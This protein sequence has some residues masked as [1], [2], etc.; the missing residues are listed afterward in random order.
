M[1]NCRLCTRYFSSSDALYRHELDHTRYACRNCGREFRTHFCALVHS[2]RCGTVSIYIFS[3]FSFSFPFRLGCDW[4]FR[5]HR[6]HSGRCSSCSSRCWIGSSWTWSER[7][8]REKNNDNNKHDNCI[9][10]IC[11]CWCHVSTINVEHIFRIHLCF[12]DCVCVAFSYKL[13]RHACFRSF[14]ICSLKYHVQS[15]TLL[16][17]RFLL[18]SFGVSK[19]PGA[20]VRSPHYGR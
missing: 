15:L 11:I 14:T 16:F 13:H 4:R 6:F 2:R 5:G 20:I 9:Q 1:F 10:W 19:L 3:F 18:V 12:L 8:Q 17:E 7:F